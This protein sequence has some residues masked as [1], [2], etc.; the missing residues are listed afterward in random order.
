LFKETHLNRGFLKHYKYG[1]ASPRTAFSSPGA[2]APSIVSSWDNTR[3]VTS[4]NISSP[5]EVTQ[6]FSEVTDWE[7]QEYFAIH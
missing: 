1:L 4:F 2:R 6:F 7:Y 5:V 3:F